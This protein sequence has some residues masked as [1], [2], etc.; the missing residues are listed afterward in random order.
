LEGVP[1]GFGRVG[2]PLPQFPES[3]NQLEGYEDQPE[4]PLR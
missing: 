1:P 2:I 3:A 4:L